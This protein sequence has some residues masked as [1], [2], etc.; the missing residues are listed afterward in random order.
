MKRIA[1]F[2]SGSGT[3][4]EKIVD[5][6]KEKETIEVVLILSNNPVAGVIE[7]ARKNKI[8][9]LIIEKKTFYETNDIVRYLL[10]LNIDLIVLAGFL[11]MIPGNLIAAFE[12]KMINIH[13]ALLP[14]YGGKGMYGINVHKAVINSGEKKTGI[15]IHHIN[16]NYDEGQIV[17]QAT[18]EIEKDDT[19]ETIAK[20]VQ[21]LE[22]KY[23]PIIIEEILLKNETSKNGGY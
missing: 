22:H 18:C 11:W 21:V 8:P 12:N 17:F 10:K 7:I 6:F 19:P 15:S 4:T 13:S 16:E 3:N 5:Y 20:K 23:F 9:T 14:K 2:A 1:I